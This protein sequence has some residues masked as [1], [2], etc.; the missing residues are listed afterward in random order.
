LIPTNRQPGTRV[1]VERFR[2]EGF[3]Q[4]AFSPAAPDLELPQPVLRHHVPLREEQV[5]V[6]P[7]VDVRNALLVADDL[8]RLLEPGQLQFAIYLRE[9]LA[10]ELVQ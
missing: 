3:S 9:R 8:D 1:V 7:R 6:I 4:A 10:C 5:V 2:P